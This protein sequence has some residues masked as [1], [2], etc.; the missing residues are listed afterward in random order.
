M[1]EDIYIVG[2]G[3]YGEVMLE[4]AGIL[5]YKVKGF[6][7]EKIEEISTVMGIKVIDKF[8]TLTEQEIKGKNF[9]VAIGNNKIRFNLMNK[10][11]QIGGKTPSLIHPSAI[12]SPSAQMGKGVYVQANVYIW[13]N[14]KI[15]DFCIISPGVVIA[16]HTTIG[17][18][19]LISTLTGVG[20]SINIEDKVFLGM[21][22]T[23][24]TGLHEI[25]ENSIIGAGAVVLK[26][27]EK[28]SVYAGV[29]AKKIRNLN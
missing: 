22:S 8:S 4:L 20:A 5:G 16:H 18:A 12:I 27:I 14:V 11:N 19:C 13:T 1:Q 2:A 7:D 6:Y 10:I 23:I 17:K 25:G 26:D 15:D 29:P 28:E 24:V 9:I 21:K 3:T